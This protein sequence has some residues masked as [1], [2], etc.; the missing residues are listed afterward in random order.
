MIT[1]MLHIRV[2]PGYEEEAIDTLSAIERHARQDTG[3]VNFTWLRDEHDLG[4]FT[5]FE[6]WESQEDLD[7]RLNADSARWARFVPC[8]AEAPRPESFR[9]VSELAA[10][11]GP[12]EVSQFVRD[13]F[14]KLSAHAPVR[15]LLPMLVTD[16]L[17]MELPEATLTSEAKFRKWYTRVGNAYYGQSYEIE[18]LEA[19]EVPGSLAVDLALSVIWTARRAG[20][21]ASLAFRARQSW[22]LVRCP[23]TGQALIARFQVREMTEIPVPALSRGAAAR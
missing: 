23:K 22:R 12:D 18:Y 2:R 15:E 10:A 16:G 8:L 7:R 17:V 11:P 20:D 14:A 19:A 5:L 13:W 21:G 3:M 6:Q 4:S 9:A 1:S